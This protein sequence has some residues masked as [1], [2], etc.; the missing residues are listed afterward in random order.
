LVFGR[1]LSKCQFLFFRNT[2]AIPLNDS[3]EDIISWH[4]GKN[5]VF[6]VKLAYHVSGISKMDTRFDIPMVLA[7]LMSSDIGVS[8]I[9]KMLLYEWRCC[10]AAKNADQVQTFGC[11]K[12]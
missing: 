8:Q 7:M 10:S 11:I 12:V 4:Y 9:K 2:L 6:S 3:I 1:I 5:G